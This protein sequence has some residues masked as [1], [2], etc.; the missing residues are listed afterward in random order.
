MNHCG[1][2]VGV[3]TAAWFSETTSVG[4]G[5]DYFSVASSEL[6]EFLGSNKIASITESVCNGRPAVESKS[7]TTVTDS[8]LQLKSSHQ[9]ILFTLCGWLASLAWWAGITSR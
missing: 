5:Q 2:V 8:D 6:L 3:N 9:R 7:L 1:N 4:V